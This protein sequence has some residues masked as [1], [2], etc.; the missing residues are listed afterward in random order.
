MKNP[1]EN[2]SKEDQR[3]LMEG[4]RAAAAPMVNGTDLMQEVQAL[5]EADH[6]NQVTPRPSRES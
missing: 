4:A 2:L 6:A 3:Q 1:L 5:Y